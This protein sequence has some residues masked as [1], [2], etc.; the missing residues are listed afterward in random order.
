MI[1]H[2]PEIIR[3][4][5]H[6]IIWSKIEMSTQ[7]DNIPDY[8]WYR[9]PDRY[10]RYLSP[11][12]DAFLAPALIAGMHFREN[13]EVRGAVSPRLK[14]HL[15]EYQFILNLRLSADLKSINI[16][17]D[18][19]KTLDAN[20]EAIGATFSGGVDSFYTL[21]MHLPDQQTIPNYSITHAL[22]INGFDIRR[23]D[24][25]KYS[26]LFARYQQLL[27][28]LDI[29][30]IPLETNLVNIIMPQLNYV[31]FYG[32]VL[33]GCGMILGKLFKRFYI[34]N[35]RDYYQLAFRASSSSPLTDRL[36]STETLDIVHYGATHRR[37]E[38]IKALSDW[39]PAQDHLRVCGVA[40]QK[41]EILNCSRCEKCT[42]TMVPLYALGKMNRFNTFLKP[43]KSNRDTLWWARKFDPRKE[44]YA[45]EIFPF[46][47]KHKQDLLIWL[48]FAAALGTARYLMLKLLPDF[49]KKWLRR[50]GFFIDKHK[51]ENAF[52]NPVIIDL[53]HAYNSSRKKSYYDHPS[54]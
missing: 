48:R 12:S 17:Y 13:I 41:A 26:L 47:K 16:H 5:G 46:T 4:Q 24:Q 33:A 14:Y 27:M 39:K 7:R 31:Y 30:L 32:P 22:F 3:H 54:A 29:Q 21:K 36:L 1:I 19:L 34:S 38:K 37:V 10:A 23:S 6:T 35:S 9:V 15:E 50:Y 43:F 51:Q 2:Q 8:L 44:N 42:R 45:P 53:I 52:D 11:L 20:P 49:I 25:N 18:H 28:D 40:E